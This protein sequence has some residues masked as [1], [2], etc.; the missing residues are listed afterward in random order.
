MLFSSKLKVITSQTKVF[1]SAIYSNKI[2]LNKEFKFT[3][4]N[5]I[6]VTY[7]NFPLQ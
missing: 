5:V 7:I 1:G 3:L 4:C 2:I 6:E